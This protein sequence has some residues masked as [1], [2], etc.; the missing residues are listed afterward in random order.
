MRN[1]CLVLGIIGV[2]GTAVPIIR[3]Q[4]WW[5]RIFDFPRLQLVGVCLLAVALYGLLS[6]WETGGPFDRFL[7]AAGALCFIYQARQIFPYTPFA[8]RQVQKAGT[9]KSFRVLFDTAHLRGKSL[10]S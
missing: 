1:L 4:A 9:S 5:I 2:V 6:F 10:I 8:S 3:N 7:A